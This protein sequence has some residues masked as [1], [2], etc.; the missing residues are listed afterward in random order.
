MDN[1]EYRINC[2]YSGTQTIDITCDFFED[3][4]VPEF[5]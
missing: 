3:F 4:V 5:L 1:D 2:N